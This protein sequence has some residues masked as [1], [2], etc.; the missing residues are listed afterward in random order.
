MGVF[1]RC[2]RRSVMCN[3]H[4]WKQSCS[5]ERTQKDIVSIIFF[6]NNYV[7][8]QKP[9]FINMKHMYRRYAFARD[10]SSSCDFFEEF[11]IRIESVQSFE[12]LR[13]CDLPLGT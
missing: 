8:T 6:V 1:L 9:L 5:V 2:F 13:V 12:Y 11:A 7:L 10:S 4:R 3:G